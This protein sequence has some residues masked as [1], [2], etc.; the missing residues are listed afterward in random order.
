[1]ASERLTAPLVIS[2]AAI[3]PPV[4]AAVVAFRFYTRKTQTA[5]LGADDWLTIPAFVWNRLA[6][7]K[8]DAKANRMHSTDLVGW[9]VCFGTSRCLEFAQICLRPVLTRIAQASLSIQSGIRLPN[10]QALTLSRTMHHISKRRL[11]RCECS[12]PSMGDFDR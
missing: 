10:Q 11:E 3:W 9:N 6:S 2:A 7:G 1:M 12:M 8:R 5:R 4:C